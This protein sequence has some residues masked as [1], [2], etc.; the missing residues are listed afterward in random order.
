MLRLPGNLAPLINLKANTNVNAEMA[1]STFRR[2]YEIASKVFH[3][4]EKQKI[5]R[6]RKQF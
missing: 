3:G 6:D 4:K 1:Y 2:I 5:E